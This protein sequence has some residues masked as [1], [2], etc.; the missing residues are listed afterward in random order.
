MQW[1]MLQQDKPEDFVIV[2]GK[3]YS[4]RQF[5]E[6]SAA[7]LGIRLRFEGSGIDERA[8]VLAIEGDKTPALK[9][10]DVVVA[11]VHVITDLSR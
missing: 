8:V 3:Q 10:G 9:V 5:I 7:E 11:I 4:V 1:M 6:W 2:T